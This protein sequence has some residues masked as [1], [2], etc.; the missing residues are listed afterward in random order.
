[1][2]LS[3]FSYIFIPIFLVAIF[4]IYQTVFENIAANHGKITTTNFFREIL[5]RAGLLLLVFL[6][7]KQWFTFIDFCIYVSLVFA[8]NTILNYV[9]VIRPM[10]LD[11]KPNWAFINSKPELKKDMINFNVWLVLSSLSLLIINKMNCEINFDTMKNI[12]NKKKGMNVLRKHNANLHA[13]LSNLPY[14]NNQ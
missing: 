13:S 8:L 7:Y 6:Y 9:F 4:R 5:T 12:K 10:K 14:T 3:Y 11:F 2:N 1:M